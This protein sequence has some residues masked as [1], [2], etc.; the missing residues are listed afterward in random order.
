MPTI[1]GLPPPC[2]SSAVVTG[3]TR[4]TDS[5][6]VFTAH[7]NDVLP[8]DAA[9]S[10]DGSM[11][12]I[13]GAGGTGLS[14]YP[15]SLVQGSNGCIT[16]T[17]GVGG[18]SVSSVAWLSNTKVV[19]LE[20]LRSTPLVFDLATGL[21]RPIGSGDRG[22]SNAAHQLF[23]SAPRG[24]A[25]LACASCH[26]EGGE[27]GHLWI[28]DGQ[29]RRTQTLAGG[30]MKRAPFHWKGDLGDLGALMADTFVK[31]MGATPVNA[32]DTASLGAW[33]DTI[34]SP[35]PSRVLSA[36]ARAAGLAAFEKASCSSCHLAGGTQE[37][38]AAD[39]GTGEA[40]R[41]P[42][43]IAIQARA[44]YLHTGELPDLRARV[45]GTLHPNHGNLSR[46]NLTEKESLLS[47]LESL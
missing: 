13:G 18:L 39:I 46:L 29:F 42:H 45:M 12:A 47:Y 40:V 22:L 19:V 26:P 23:H 16:P 35:K 5:G 17:G 27:D 15:T 37:G 25:A 34:P 43:L 24:G 41:S 9:L 28:I 31:R 14:V 1:P 3:V 8:V 20:S 32:T 6:D 33:L 7:T 44:P 38:P 2:A 10:P 21:A 36:D 11:L 4:V 30:V